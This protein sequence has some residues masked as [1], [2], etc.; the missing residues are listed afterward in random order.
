MMFSG[1][2]SNSVFF[3]MTFD[4]RDDRGAVSEDRPSTVDLR[5][6]PVAGDFLDDEFLT[7]LIRAG[8]LFR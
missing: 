7:R 2:S 3:S 8:G 6:P 1:V 5:P 4:F